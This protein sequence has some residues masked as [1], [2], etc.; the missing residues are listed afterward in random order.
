MTTLAVDVG[1]TKIEAAIVDD[2]GNVHARAREAT[3]SVGAEGPNLAERLVALCGRVRR[4]ARLVGLADP[5]RSTMTRRPWLSLKAGSGELRVSI[6]IWRWWCRR[7]W[8]RALLSTADCSTVPRVM[9]ATSVT[10]SSNP[11]GDS[12]RVVRGVA[13]KPKPQVRQSRLGRVW[14][15]LRR[16]VPFVE[17]SELLLGA[18]W[19]AQSACLIFV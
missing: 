12:A 7:V 16:Q 15:P 17:S 2:L 9:L 5:V 19:L 18:Q 13:S 11:R 3:A 4:E 1:G 8:V 6:T 10:S 14:R